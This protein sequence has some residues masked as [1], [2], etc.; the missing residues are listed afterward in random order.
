MPKYQVIVTDTYLIEG[1]TKEEV[2]EQI[3]SNKIKRNDF[4][5]THTIVKRAR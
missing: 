2:E 5:K 1:R 3:R 4:V